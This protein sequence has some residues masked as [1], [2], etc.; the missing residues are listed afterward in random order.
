MTVA[1]ANNAEG[2]VHSYNVDL[3]EQYL[4]V[5]VN[6]GAP[7]DLWCRNTSSWQTVKTATCNLTLTAGENVVTLTNDGLHR[8]NGQP[9]EIPHVYSVTLRPVCS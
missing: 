6:C 9:A 3:I 1:Y 5:T 7:Q 2:G 4:T 8:F